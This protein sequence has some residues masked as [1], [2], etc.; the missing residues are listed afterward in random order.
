MAARLVIAIH[1]DGSL[2]RQYE[3][4]LEM[5]QSRMFSLG[6]RRWCADM[7]C[8]P[9]LPPV[10]FS[11]KEVGF[12]SFF[13]RNSSIDVLHSLREA[14][15]SVDVLGVSVQHFLPLSSPVLIT[16][17][18]KK[19]KKKMKILVQGT[20][21]QCVDFQPCPQL[22]TLELCPG[23]TLEPCREIFKDIDANNIA[24]IN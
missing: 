11:N 3:T 16:C 13:V 7:F 5:V 20:R 8:T 9:S 22:P 14:E 17:Q 12:P 18:S 21:R 4:H 15:G 19:K 6:R 2:P 10:L 24:L 1:R 23:C